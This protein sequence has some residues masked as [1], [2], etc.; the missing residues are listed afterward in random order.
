M[1]RARTAFD[2]LVSMPPALLLDETVTYDT[3]VRTMLSHH[4]TMNSNGDKPMKY[5]VRIHPDGYVVAAIGDVRGIST[6]PNLLDALA[7]C[8]VANRYARG[9]STFTG[10]A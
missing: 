9:S 8:R 7:V 5:E 1:T 10:A 3:Q 6:H 4:A 2:T